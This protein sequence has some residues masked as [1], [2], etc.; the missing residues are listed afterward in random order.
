MNLMRRIFVNALLADASYVDLQLEAPATD[1]SRD[2]K[3]RMTPT[4]AAYI[5][6]NFEVASVI[7][8]SDIP[9]VGSGFDATVWRGRGDGGYAGQVFV[10]T[11]GTQ[12][13]DGGADLLADG[14]LVLVGARSQIIDMINWWL[15]ETTPVGAQAKQVQWDPLRIQPGTAMTLEPGVVLGEAV[16]GQGHLVGVSS[17]QVNGHS[18]GGHLAAA[19]ARIFGADTPAIGSVRVESIDTFNSAGFNGDNAEF[20][21]AQIQ[22]LLGTGLPSFDGVQA[23]QTNF[24]AENGYEVTTNTWWFTQMGDRVALNQEEGFAIANHSMYRITDLL[25]LGVAL[26]KLDSTLTI[27]KLNE[28]VD[29]GSNRAEGS[30]EGVLDAVRRM[31]DPYAS[32]TP[33]G[34][35]KD[36]SPARLAY[37][38]ALAQWQLDPM[39]TALAG[40]VRISPTSEFDQL[41]SHAKTDFGAFL[42]LHSLS[43]VVMSTQNPAAADA[44]Q[45]V[46]QGLAIAWEADKN[47][48]LYGDTSYAYTFSDAWYEDRAS[49]LRA[50][51]VRNEQDN[52]TGEVFDAQAAA[53]QAT[54]FDF[55]DPATGEQIV[56]STRASGAQGL[57]DRHI[58]FGGEQGDSL[59]GTDNALGDRLY[60]GAGSDTLIGEGGND[61]LEGGAG[62]DSLEG[63]ADNDT[64]VGGA[65]S[66]TYRFDASNWGHDV[67]V[68][69]DG[70]GSIE[71][72]GVA[73]TE[74]HRMPGANVWLDPTE[75]YIIAKITRTSSEVDLLIAPKAASGTATITVRNWSETRNLGITMEPEEAA[76]EAPPASGW[77]YWVQSGGT[78]TT[79]SITDNYPWGIYYPELVQVGG[80]LNDG[81]TAK[82]SG[83][84]LIG[85]A[86]DDVMG[87]LFPFWLHEPPVLREHL[88]PYVS[89]EL[90][91]YDV[92]EY[93]PELDPGP[94]YRVRAERITLLGGQGNDHLVSG[95][96]VVDGDDYSV[97]ASYFDGGEGHD[98]IEVTG[99]GNILNG[100]S[101]DDQIDVSGTGNHLF[102]GAGNDELTMHWSEQGHN[103]AE[104]GEGD[105]TIRVL[106]GGAA[107]EPGAH[108]TIVYNRG[109]GEDVVYASDAA[110]LELR[111]I[112]HEELHFARN[113][114]P[115]LATGPDLVLTVLGGEHE[116][117]VT[118]KDYFREEYTSREGHHVSSRPLLQFSGGTPWDYARVVER[119][120]QGGEGADLLWGVDDLPE[121]TLAGGAGNDLLYAGDGI[122]TFVFN[123]GDGHDTVYEMA[124]SHKTSGA[125]QGVLKLGDGLSAT[126]VLVARGQGDGAADDLMLIFSGGDQ[127]TLKNYFN[128]AFRLKTIHFAGGEQWGYAQVVERLNQGTSGPDTLAGV[129]DLPNQMFGGAGNDILKANKLNDTLNGGPGDDILYTGVGINT[130]VYE[131][132]DGQDTLHPQLQVSKTNRVNQDVLQLGAGLTPASTVLERAGEY[133]SDLVLRFG[134]GDQ[135]TLLN[136][137]LEPFRLSAITFADGTQWDYATVNSLLTTAGTGGD[138]MLMGQPDAS[139]HL[140]G[141]GGNDMLMGGALNDVLHGGTGTDMVSGGGGD[142]RYL[143]NLGDGQDSISDTGGHDR[144]VFG[145]GITAG[146]ISASEIVYAP[147][148]SMVTVNVAPGDSLSFEGDGSGSSSAIEDLEFADGSV[149]TLQALLAQNNPPPPPPPPDY[150]LPIESPTTH[151][152]AEHYL[153]L[154]LTGNAA[155]D[156]TGNSEANQLTG[157]SAANVLSGGSGDDIYVYH[158][159]GGADTLI[160]L[161][162]EGHDTLRLGEGITPTPGSIRTSREGSDL[163]LSFGAAG[164]SDQVRMPGYFDVDGGTVETIAFANGRQWNFHN[165]MGWMASVDA[166]ATKV[167]YNLRRI[168]GDE[169]DL[170]HPVLGLGQTSAPVIHIIYGSSWADTLH[171]GA[172]M[173]VDA[174]RLGLGADSIYFTGRLDD[175][176]QAIDQDSGIYTLA[177]R[178]RTSE[179]IQFTSMGEDDVLH[180]ADGHIVFNALTDA[181]LYDENT[182]VFKPIQA[183]YLLPGGTP[184]NAPDATLAIQGIDGTTVNATLSRPLATVLT[185]AQAQ[186]SVAAGNPMLV[187]VIGVNGQ[188]IA[189]LQRSGQAMTVRGGSGVDTVYVTPGTA[190]DARVLSLGA[191]RIYFTGEFSDYT[192][193][194]DLDAGVYTFTHKTRPTEVVKITSTGQNDELWFADGHIVFNAFTDTRLYDWDADIFQAVQ[195]DWLSPGGTPIHTE[196]LEVS[197]DGGATWQDAT[198]FVNGTTV[199][200]TDAA[201][202]NG[203]TAM[204]RVASQTAS[205]AVT[206]TQVTSDADDVV[207]IGTAEL[208]SLA[209]SSYDG[210]AGMDTLALKN[211]QSGVLLDLTAY[212][213]STF[214]GIEQIDLTG[215]GNNTAKL[216]IDQLLH[217]PDAGEERLIVLGDAGDS[218]H[219]V[220]GSGSWSSAGTQ[221]WQGLDYAVYA[222]SGALERELLV[223]QGVGVLVV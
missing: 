158:L 32:P 212:G 90:G 179:V 40:S 164:T 185:D 131:R 155:I 36:S 208:A 201:L 59:Q 60:G 64:L 203:S 4:Q 193:T 120:N 99:A 148:M 6:A 50:I 33:V 110:T 29:A 144:I 122:N 214:T 194:I 100:A 147:G 177:H 56:L 125:N 169:L 13:E 58:L 78:F 115:V 72:G 15:R 67:I 61:Y 142:D 113:L 77:D 221:N 87:L 207:L 101:G 121:Q 200:I 62:S 103:T 10:S 102:G 184:V 123:R 97:R 16:A 130:F 129:D 112:S 54:F 69:A 11:R 213:Q 196:R 218:V 70:Q 119:M 182:G 132:G 53:G 9:L 139:N 80:P 170:A 25:A 137:F 136:Y 151:T 149:L 138:D 95:P 1:I 165:V 183:S 20:F 84:T 94:G 46:H 85:G 146:Q 30:L 209:H 39:F 105:D 104:G 89:P 79:D 49:L 17:V 217:M 75:A 176:L 73:L 28:L 204:L 51:Q 31:L 153:N 161:S 178:T 91:Y 96:Y 111:G 52:T 98:R 175:Y 38:E 205:G 37:H 150:T 166:P 171:I 124:S 192:Q 202:T 141:G 106:D 191:D 74:L 195:A 134:Q 63:G 93:G 168:G 57:A 162:G 180:F 44:L 198:A 186:G 160:E 128:P 82:H 18:L 206:A 220:S 156:G 107:M 35:D 135:I 133:G 172:G 3:E 76:P 21:F 222:H 189:P 167:K 181:R 42:A 117:Q 47:A 7:N 65:G 219:L 71:I 24:F 210:G 163:I 127:V 188:D 145:A 143:F 211:D 154:I 66:D 14:D 118:V 86:G 187:Y 55:L 140:V 116:G 34:D 199:T 23:K 126:A 216:T 173:Q 197:T 108:A 41:S 159:G 190:I 88:R 109:D 81:L 5:A 45:A 223:Q 83:A 22:E 152:L 2:L 27:E 12:P 157:N 174:L 8:S 68:D 215:G 19:F 92:I 26:E 48:R 114:D 43:P